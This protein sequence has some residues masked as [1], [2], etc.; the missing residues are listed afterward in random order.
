M[1]VLLSNAFTGLPQTPGA[2]R[3]KQNFCQL[4][5]VLP[6]VSGIIF[7]HQSHSKD[8]IDISLRLS[9]KD[10]TLNYFIEQLSNNPNYDEIHAS[11]AWKFICS[12]LSKFGNNFD[13]CWL[14]FDDEHLQKK[15][16]SPSILINPCQEQLHNSVSNL[17]NE[18]TDLGHGDF[19][20]RTLQNFSI[21]TKSIASESFKEI[22]IHYVG[23]MVARGS[24][25]IRCCIKIP[26]LKLKEFVEHHQLPINSTNLQRATHCHLLDYVNEVVLSI[27]IADQVSSRIGIEYPIKNPDSASSLYRLLADSYSLDC[28]WI[29]DIWKRDDPILSTLLRKRDIFTIPFLSEQKDH[30]YS[31][32]SRRFNHLKLV[33]DRHS[34]VELKTY[35]Y[36]AFGWYS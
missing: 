33:F 7:E 10:G 36:L 3:L 26:L 14:E 31:T 6:V 13:D 22:E 29:W 9:N 35:L 15:V 19:S 21:L 11:P 28:E 4:M 16:P 32:Y 20:S 18:L 2:E 24:S 5:S 27:D 17:I 25:S 1:K 30:T 34:Q 12:F 8:T 23:I